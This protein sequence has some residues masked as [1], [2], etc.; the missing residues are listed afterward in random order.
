MVGNDVVLNKI[1]E[2]AID[3]IDKR[4]EQEISRILNGYY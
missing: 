3:T 2:I 1:Q 4:V